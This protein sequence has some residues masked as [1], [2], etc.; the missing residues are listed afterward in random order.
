MDPEHPI[1]NGHSTAVNGIHHR[2]T[3]ES[4]TDKQHLDPV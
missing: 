3:D 4:T 1:T 2:Q